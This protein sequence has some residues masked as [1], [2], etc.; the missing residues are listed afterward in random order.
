MNSII[1]AKTTL[2]KEII[3]SLIFLTIIILFFC[4]LEK[5]SSIPYQVD[6]LITRGS[7]P[8]TNRSLYGI[9]ANIV[10]QYDKLSTSL[11]YLSFLS[12]ILV[13]IGLLQLIFG[14]VNELRIRFIRFVRILLLSYICFSI[15]PM[16]I[17]S[18]FQLHYQVGFDSCWCGENYVKITHQK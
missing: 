17:L 12:L 16:M 11:R 3:L 2:K 6:V 9:Y 5:I 14:R 10:D 4:S 7:L 15:I 1:N 18:A 13:G 8:I